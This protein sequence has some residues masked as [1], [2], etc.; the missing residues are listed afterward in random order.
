MAKQGVDNAEMKK[1]GMIQQKQKEYFALR[2]RVVGGDLNPDQFRKVAE[3]AEIYGDGNIHITTRQGIEIHNVY[4][5]KLEKAKDELQTV[6]I[7]MGACGPR[8]R[9]VVACPGNKTCRWGSIETKGIAARIDEKYFGSEAPH[10]FKFGVTGCPHNCAKA[11]E[12]DIG[13]MGGILPKWQEEG[14]IDCNLCVNVCPTQAICCEKGRYFLD[15]QKCIN[16]SICTASCPTNSWE[17]EKKGYMVLIGGT[18]GK[19]PR[20][21]SRLTGIVE[22]QDDLMR[23][24]DAAF[25]Y[26]KQHGRK[27]ERFGHMID[28]IGLE[29]TKRDILNE[30]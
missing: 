21:A 22:N 28:R 18:M 24:I 15:E 7:R 10:K 8:V 1:I 26:Y 4:Y 17:I 13:I 19:I 25:S 5:T 9:I 3:I 30:I 11:S 27:K 2:L 20:L 14:C 6:G 16:C 23:Y 12:N 29:K